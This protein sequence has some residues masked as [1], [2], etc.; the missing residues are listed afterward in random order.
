MDIMYVILGLLIVLLFYSLQ[1]KEAF[2]IH[3]EGGDVVTPLKETV[4]SAANGVANGIR[5]NITRPAYSTLVGFV[6]YRHHYRKLRR[7][8]YAK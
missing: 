3:I 5:E 4:T 8:F 1:E 7:Q 2:T 6:P